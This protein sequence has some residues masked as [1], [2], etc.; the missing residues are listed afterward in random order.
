MYVRGESVEGPAQEHEGEYTSKVG[1]RWM[2]VHNSTTATATATA[3]M[4]TLSYT[5]IIH[6]FLIVS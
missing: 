2:W 1:M 4:T 3:H 5:C 6:G